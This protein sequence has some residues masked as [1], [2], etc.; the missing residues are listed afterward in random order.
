MKGYY[1]QHIRDGTHLLWLQRGLVI[2]MT[3]IDIHVRDIHTMPTCHGPRTHSMCNRVACGVRRHS[4]GPTQNYVDMSEDGHNWLHG[5]RQF[6]VH[7]THIKSKWMKKMCLD[8]IPMGKKGCELQKL[9]HSSEKRL[10][11]H[12]LMYQTWEKSHWD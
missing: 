3:C 1:G 9:V 2:P 4:L 12:D 10:A 11:W 5:Y 7:N 6:I 8:G